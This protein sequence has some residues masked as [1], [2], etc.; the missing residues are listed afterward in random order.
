MSDTKRLTELVD[1]LGE[2]ASLSEKSV[3]RVRDHG[4][5]CYHE[6]DLSDRRGI[7]IDLAEEAEGEVWLRI[8]RLQRTDP[9]LP[10]PELRDWIRVSN[11][12]AKAPEIQR[13]I[14]RTL[15]RPQ[16]DA[17]VEA[18][19]AD[20]EDVSTPMRE[21]ADP[22]TRD[23]FLRLDRDPDTEAA[24]QRYI[25]EVWRPWADAE[26]PVRETIRIYDRLFSLQ[27]SIET[28]GAEKP[29]EVVCGIGMARWR[30]DTATFDVP[31]VEQ[32]VEIEIGEE[33]GAI[34]VRPRQS[35]PALNSKPFER[36]EIAGV[37]IL[38]DAWRKHRARLSD[39]E[40]EVTPFRRDTFE[41]VL[42][43]AAH[44]LDRQG[45][46]LP[47]S[48][49]EA[50]DKTLPEIGSNLQ[51]TDTWVLFDRPRSESFIRADLANLK[52]AIQ[53]QD[54]KD[55]PA[56]ARR[57]VSTPPRAE[58]A[59]GPA[60]DLS[61]PLGADAP[62]PAPADESD[63]DTEFL[64]P[65]AANEEQRQIIRRLEREDGVV[66]KGPPGTGKTHTIAN[67]VCHYMAHGKRVLVTSKGESALSVLRDQIPEEVRELSISLLT[68]ER[69][70]LRQLDRAVSILAE[71]TT[72]IDP[73]ALRREI[74]STGK[75]IVALRGDIQ[76]I[77]AQLRRWAETHLQEIPV[78]D[79]S[80]LPM[81]LARRVVEERPEHA[82]FTD[83]PAPDESGNPDITADD[84]ARLAAA[85][86]RLGEDIAYLNATL[87]APANLPDAARIA[88]IHEDLAGA[89][90]LTRRAEE[91]RLPRLSATAKNA[92]ERAQTLRDGLDTLIAA[93]DAVAEAP[94]LASAL[95]RWPDGE[96]DEMEALYGELLRDAVTLAGQ[97]ARFLRTEVEMPSAALDDPD[98]DAALERLAAGRRAFPPF[99]LG[100][101][102]AKEILA[103]T[104]VNGRAPTTAEDGQAARDYLTW[105]RKVRRLLGRWRKLSPEFDLPEP[106]E[107]AD[108]AGRWL[109]DLKEKID[110]VDA[111]AGVVA[112]TVRPELP[113]LF[114]HG[115]DVDAVE[116]DRDEASRAREAVALNVS[117]HR[118]A[119]AR[120]K[121]QDIQ[122]RLQGCDGAVI[123]RMRDVLESRLGDPDADT[124]E[125]Q[126]AWDEL[127]VELSR[128]RDL[129]EDF[130]IVREVADRIEASGAPEWARRL[131]SEPAPSDRDPLVPESWRESWRWA[132][133]ESLLRRID[134]RAELR[135]LGRRR[136]QADADLRAA[137]TELVRLRTYAGL[138][139][140]LDGAIRSAL[141]KFTNAIKKIGKGTGQSAR[142]YR[143]YAREAMADCYAAV[144]CWIMPEW[145]VSES[146]PAS[147]GSFDLVIVDEASQSDV[148]ALP[149]LLRA[150]KILCV[151]DDKQVSP[152]TVGLDERTIR[153]LEHNFLKDQAHRPQ[154]LPGAS[155]YDLMTVAYPGEQIMLREHFRCVEPIIRFSMRFYT[156]P[157]LP[158]RVPKPSERLDPPL[159]DILVPHGR[160]SAGKNAKTNRAEADV[161]VRE[162]AR[163]IDDP[164]F[165]E[166]KIGVISLIGATQAQLVQRMLLETIGEAAF[167]RH[168]ITCGDAATFQGNEADVVFLSMVADPNS[169]RAVTSTMFQQRYNVAL[170]RARDRM[171]LVRSV[172]DNLLTNPNDLKA[173]AVQHFRDPMA[174]ADDG[175]DDLEERCQ[176]GFER[177]V[178]ARLRADGYRVTP[179]VPAAG[180]AIDLVVEGD[181]DARLAIE[182]DGD[183]YHG[184]EQWW[185]DFQR[186][187]ALERVGWRFWRCWGSSWTIDPEGCYADLV[188]ELSELGI[189]PTGDSDQPRASLH[190]VRMVA[191][192]DHSTRP[193]RLDEMATGALLD[194]PL[195]DDRSAG[196]GADDGAKV[197]GAE[198]DGGAHDATLAQA[199][200]EPTR[201]DASPANDD[202]AR[203]TDK[204]AQA[205]E[206]DLDADLSDD[207]IIEVGDAVVVVYDDD[208]GRQIKFTISADRDDP[209]TGIVYKGK[210]LSRALLGN[211]ADDEIEVEAGG[212]RRTATILRVDKAA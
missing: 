92:V 86:R 168:R 150:K 178:Y 70:G 48:A 88:A 171:V 25:D 33:D 63:G 207:P 184:P 46:Y 110:T 113:V 95:R 130:D 35:A 175:A 128:L 7:H 119:S 121:R 44:H 142:R 164:A 200:E 203:D 9:D 105:R 145:R 64:F 99:T 196:D 79:E 93:H 197:D 124:R 65:K 186:Q 144:P 3:D 53:E 14:V 55:V 159:V 169:V 23:V 176:S 106:P 80:M 132:Q 59:N 198:V 182:L 61:A 120:A 11:D 104:R 153:R 185:D 133:L 18:G 212:R 156:K 72:E 162:I 47:E 209:D 204:D 16:A 2:I 54:E 52:E 66:V 56:A 73:N 13:T 27:Q 109:Q 28:E 75:R 50:G 205:A 41:P 24:L 98:I 163:M 19:K 131:R 123:E 97:R 179:Q 67:I 117:R 118:L 40:L 87:T 57:L 149:A 58:S 4:G 202:T 192:R 166:R 195:A 129:A 183:K 174:G 148:Q 152:S 37:E 193:S 32:L 62:A 91:E 100:K 68:S 167:Q 187:Q 60:I 160:R 181:N 71:E 102:Q 116:R 143:R 31:L 188:R 136:A 77:D 201:A 101:R 5:I 26:A 139:N 69:E 108:D 141:T 211:G 208:P 107:R 158:M 125:V 17:L 127:L 10:D 135:D 6:V 154:L 172:P 51:V 94:W 177:D 90:R 189:E 180:Y 190:T 81:D 112:D 126:D 39:E 8:D 147:L 1:Y 206:D 199:I 210:P 140:N 191:L 12:P 85:R 38:V 161:I 84:A 115:L 138:H 36:H 122:D 29:R 76:E 78:G 20:A 43:Q 15:P 103:R 155:L 173:Q 49:S 22:D 137:F 111:G 74:A 134:G 157:M 146:L 151:G 165:A 42:K 170:S 114:P 45:V 83:R 21:D 34:R 96:S 89:E 82:W 30:T 194:E